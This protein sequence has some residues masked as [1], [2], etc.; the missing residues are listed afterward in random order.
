MNNSIGLKTEGFQLARDIDTLM[1]SALAAYSHRFGNNRVANL[2]L[3]IKKEKQYSMELIAYI[4]DGLISKGGIEIKSGRHCLF[5]NNNK[6]LDCLFVE[7]MIY[8]LYVKPVYDNLVDEQGDHILT[9]R[10]LVES[11]VI[12]GNNEL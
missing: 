11:T 1:N 5:L 4:S 7:L 6:Y 12:K 3:H 8:L 10:D 9:I 2:H